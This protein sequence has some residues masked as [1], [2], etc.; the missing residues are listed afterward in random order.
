M[1]V[2]LF[3]W[4]QCWAEIMDVQQSNHALGMGNDSNDV[5]VRLWDDGT[6]ELWNN[7]IL[8]LRNG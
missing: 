8:E 7:G 1:V 4:L 2:W 5:I 6:I 3:D